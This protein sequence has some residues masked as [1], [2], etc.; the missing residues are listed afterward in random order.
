MERLDV[1]ISDLAL[2]LVVAGITTVIFKRIKQPLVLGYVLAGFL[3]STHFSVLP[4]IADAENIHMWADLGVIFIMFALGLE[5]SFHKIANIGGSA[6][7]TAVTLIT[8]M[9]FVGYGVGQA[10]GWSQMDSIFLG[11]MISLSSTMIILKAYEELGLKNK[12]YAQLVLG[13]LILEDVVAIFM[14][15]ILSTISISQ[16]VSG[17]DLIQQLGTLILYLVLWLVLGI[18]LIPTGL[19][20]ADKYLNDETL[21]IVSLGLCLAMVVIANYMGFSSALGAFLAGSILAGTVKA[22]RIEGLVNPIK[23]LFGAVFFVSVGMLVNPDMILKYLVP[24][25]ILTVVTILGQMTFAMLG[26]LLS[27]NS[28][29]TAV[30]AGLSMVQIGEFSFIIASLGTTLGVTSDFLYPIVVSVSVITT[31]TTPMFIKRIEPAYVKLAKILPKQ[32]LKTLKTYTSERQTENEKDADWKAYLGQYIPRT[33]ITSI[34]LFSIYVV[35]IHVIMPFL[36]KMEISV[37]TSKIIACTIAVMA[38]APIINLMSY[39]RKTIYMKLWLKKKTNRPPLLAFRVVRIL[40][41]IFFVMIT[42]R[43]L[44]SIPAWILWWISVII[45]IFS[46]KSDFM[47][48]NSI[49]MET[50]FMAN[51]NERILSSNKKK[52]GISGHHRWLDETLL[53]GKYEVKKLL[54]DNSERIFFA[55]RLLG[56]HIVK[57]IRGEIHINNPD[58]ETGIQAGDIIVALGKQYNLDSYSLAIDKVAEVLKLDEY[59]TLRNYSYGQIFTSTDVENHLLCIA[60]NV[61][62]DCEFCK[63][64]IQMSRIREKYFGFVIGIERDMLSI[65]G[66]NKNMIIAEGDLLWVLGGQD[67]LNLFLQEG[68]L[69][70]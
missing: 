32:T 47:M 6:I 28:L 53:V 2:I 66:P 44:T 69:T 55:R 45:V 54:V 59:L 4:S 14:M 20:K 34:I 33:I 40:L 17:F 57:I 64:T 70:N 23:D 65:V 29:H 37:L 61:T 19:K 22:E 56:V 39:K 42:I 3:T 68:I 50:R 63:K 62:K 41:S 1:L 5:F 13:T 38:M 30:G 60:I 58:M 18:Y 35:V 67:T 15:I 16:N 51:F 31:F 7:V 24:I 10:M 12:K 11:G 26:V 9:V 21:L 49:K 27:G 36:L 48:S 25:L 43:E 52:R 46:M 8:A